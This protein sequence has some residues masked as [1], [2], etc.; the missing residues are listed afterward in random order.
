MRG[1]VLAEINTKNVRIEGHDEVL[2]QWILAD[3]N[4]KKIWH[5]K[6]LAWNEVARKFT[7]QL[8][9]DTRVLISNFL[10]KDRFRCDDS[11]QSPYEIHF[12]D[13]TTLTAIG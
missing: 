3:N 2:K 10:V 6:L 11:G 12:T 4:L 1:Y 5:V 9:E 13:R 8:P 7:R